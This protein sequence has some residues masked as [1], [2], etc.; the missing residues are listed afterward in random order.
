MASLKSLTQGMS[1]FE[2]LLCVI[3][4]LVFLA[5]VVWLSVAIATFCVNYVLVTLGYKP[6]GMLFVWVC[7]ILLSWVG[8]YFRTSAVKVRGE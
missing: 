7:M 5:A 3:G 6:V 8:S 1:G 2:V 4:A